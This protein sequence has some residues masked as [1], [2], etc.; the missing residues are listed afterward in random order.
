[1]I[2]NLIYRLTN[3]MTN[4]QKNETISVFPRGKNKNKNSRTLV[5]REKNSIIIKLNNDVI[6]KKKKK[7]KNGKFRKKK[8][9]TEFSF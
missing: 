2:N 9:F 1:M 4:K 6:G 5:I 8:N 7:L 3:Q